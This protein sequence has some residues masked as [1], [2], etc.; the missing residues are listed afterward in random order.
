MKFKI[1]QVALH[2]KDPAKAK[3]LLTAMG[4]GAWAEDVV[5][6][7]GVVHDEARI[8][9]AALSFEYNLLDHANELEVLHYTEGDNWMQGQNRVSHIGMHCDEAELEDW[10]EFFKA[11]GIGIA[12]EVRT[13]SHTNPHIAGKRWYHYC[14]FDT[15]EILSVDVKF[16]VR[17]DYA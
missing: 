12:Q 13:M 3:E 16:I 10:K 9:K 14:I 4:A 1:E 11:R 8:N 5:E 15:H 7:D 17:R 2:P 6:A